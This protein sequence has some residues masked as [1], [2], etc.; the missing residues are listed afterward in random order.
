MV[1]GLLKRICKEKIGFLSRYKKRLFYKGFPAL[2]AKKLYGFMAFNKNGNHVNCLSRNPFISSLTIQD[3]GHTM[4]L[5]NLIA[6]N[7]LQR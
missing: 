7:L 5:R 6:I 4:I 1:P 3:S 2:G